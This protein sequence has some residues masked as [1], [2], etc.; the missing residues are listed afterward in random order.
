MKVCGN[1][2]EAPT[3][4]ANQSTTYTKLEANNLLDAKAN[5]STTYTITQVN[6]LL[7]SKLNLIDLESGIKNRITPVSPLNYSVAS[8]ET[9]PGIFED[10]TFL[11]LDMTNIY[12]K[13]QVNALIPTTVDAYTKSETYTKTEVN[14]ALATKAN[15]SSTYTQPQVDNMIAA[16]G[17]NIILNFRCNLEQYGKI[18]NLA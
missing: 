16:R 15:R 2:D 10:K 17:E 6:N 9:S 18:Q 7:N 11:N 14:S 4:K 3:T 12:T 5:H 1:T 13:A 8:V